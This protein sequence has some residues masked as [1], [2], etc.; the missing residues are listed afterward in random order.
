M[1]SDTL[2][3]GVRIKQRL[4]KDICGEVR[5]VLESVAREG[6]SAANAADDHQDYFVVE[7]GG[8]ALLF[9]ACIGQHHSCYQQAGRVQ[10][11]SPG[12]IK[13]EIR[14]RSQTRIGGVPGRVLAKFHDHSAIL[15]RDAS[16][17]PLQ[18]EDQLDIE[19]I[20]GVSCD[21]TQFLF[22]QIPMPPHRH[23]VARERSSPRS[24]AL[25]DSV[26]LGSDGAITRAWL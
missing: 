6:F 22:N 7:R 12:T 26:P 15:P 3:A 5:N 9:G 21:D 19:R 25:L 13:K 2:I 10:E 20:I 17:V 16:G 24:S 14:N 23:V 11:C 8:C 1:C 18:L 4:R